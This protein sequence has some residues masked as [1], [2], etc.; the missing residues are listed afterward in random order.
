MKKSLQ[1]LTALAITLCMT[2]SALPAFAQQRAEVP[3]VNSQNYYRMGGSDSMSRA[4]FP[5]TISLRLGLGGAARLSYSCGKLSASITI[6][7]IMTQ[8][9]QFAQQF[10]NGVQAAI[11]SLPM[12][13]LQRANPGLYELLQTYIKKAEVEWNVALKTC[14]EYEAIIKSGGDPYENWAKLAK[15][16]S[17]KSTLDSSSSDS[18]N[19]V[20][21]KSKVERRNGL[22]G[23]TWIGGGKRGGEGQPALEVIKDLTKAG[24]DATINQSPSINNTL[25]ATSGTKLASIWANDAQ[26]SSWLVDVVGD[27]LV[28]TCSEPAC[29]QK[30]SVAGKGLLPKFEQEITVVTNQMA[31]ALT[32]RVPDNATLDAASAP[33]VAVSRELTDALRAMNAGERGMAVRRLNMEI[34]QARTIDKALIARNLLT[35]GMSVPEASDVA[36]ADAR[37][38]LKDLNRMIDDMMFEIRVRREIVSQTAGNV[39]DQYTRTQRESGAT[40]VLPTPDSRVL[41]DGRV[42]P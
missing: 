40:A 34:A 24:Y 36:L 41:R 31:A 38:K 35:T 17:W 3:L 21:V 25:S 7:A 13:I 14:E 12:Y 6:N 10:V 37:E 20:S 42:K 4:P 9:Q 28:G 39:I 2:V 1:Q 23:V 18:Q 8:I 16:E 26:A 29:P 32:T 27:R 33:G 5:S 11:A 30:G 19:A 22:D 15:G